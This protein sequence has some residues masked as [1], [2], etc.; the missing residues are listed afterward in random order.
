M[1]PAWTQAVRKAVDLAPSDEERILLEHLARLLEDLGEDPSSSE[2]M[3]RALDY[4]FS[5]I[6]KAEKLT[7]LETGYR[8]LA[9][10]PERTAGERLVHQAARR[11][12]DEP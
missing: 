3:R 5:S 8:L 11:V 4:F 12:A 9:E 10:D 7:R 6:E 1:L 2:V